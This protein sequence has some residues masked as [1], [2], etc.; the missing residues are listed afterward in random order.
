[1]ADQ[2]DQKND[3]SLSD[4]CRV[5]GRK[6]SSIQPGR[7]GSETKYLAKDYAS[8]LEKCFNVKVL[9][10]V[11][12]MAPEYFCATCM[13][14]VNRAREAESKGRAFSVSGGCGQVVSEWSG[15][16]EKNKGG[17]RPK[18]QRKNVIAASNISPMPDT[19]QSEDTSGHDMTEEEF[20][21]SCYTNIQAQSRP[22]AVTCCS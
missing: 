12:G 4:V 8:D 6:F 19:C 10:D 5:G 3:I 9:T 11:E 13:K 22:V 14:V 16:I 21:C 2:K 20:F 15:A 17:R 18:R 7:K 1:M